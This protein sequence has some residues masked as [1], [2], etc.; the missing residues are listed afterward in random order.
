MQE[1]SSQCPHTFVSVQ[2]NTATYTLGQVNDMNQPMI[3]PEPI[4]TIKTAGEIKLLL[5]CDTYTP[6]IHL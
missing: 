2:G 1:H 5:S 4:Q 3:S 6:G